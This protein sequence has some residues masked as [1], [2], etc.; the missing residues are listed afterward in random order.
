MKNICIHVVAFVS[1]AFPASAQMREIAKACTW[2]FG[3]SNGSVIARS[4]RLV[5]SSDSSGSNIS[6][7]SNPNEHTWSISGDKLIFRNTSGDI[8]TRFNSASVVGGKLVL[9]GD[10]VTNP[11]FKHTLQCK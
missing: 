8:T 2:Q 6:G 5:S 11:P 10:I 4:I 9:N 1:L 3:R 7:Y